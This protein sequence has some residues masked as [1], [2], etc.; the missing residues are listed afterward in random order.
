MLGGPIGA[1]M[2]KILTCWLEI[3]NEYSIR[4]AKL[5]SVGFDRREALLPLI[6]WNSHQGKTPY[7]VLARI[8][9]V[10]DVH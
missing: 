9:H 10:A 3:R 5:L 2:K 4:I 6:R 1:E 8:V 7:V